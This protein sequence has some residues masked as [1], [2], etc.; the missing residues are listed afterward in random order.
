MRLRDLVH[1]SRI[2][3]VAVGVAMLATGCRSHRAEDAKSGPEVIYARAQKA[4]KNSSYAEAIKQLESLQ[5]RLPL[6]VK[7][8]PTP[9]WITPTT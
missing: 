7:I 2:L 6:Y 8:R 1:P 3:L 4:I 9:G 5:S